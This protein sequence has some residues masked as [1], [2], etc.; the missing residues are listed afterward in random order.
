MSNSNETFVIVDPNHMKIW[1]SG[2]KSRALANRAIEACMLRGHRIKG[3]RP[4][5]QVLERL[6]VMSRSEFNRLDEEIEVKNLMSGKMVKI[7]RSQRGTCTDPST[8]AY[9]Q[10]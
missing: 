7:R 10:M 6:G 1:G 8:E 3:N 9:W 5:V 2:Y 4:P